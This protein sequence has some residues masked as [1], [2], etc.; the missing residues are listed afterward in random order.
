MHVATDAEVLKFLADHA[1][2][3]GIR[4]DG[5]TLYY[6][7]SGANC[8]EL[9][10]PKTPLKTTYFARVAAMMGISEEALFYGATLWIT[11]S[12]IGSPQLEKSGWKL[13][14]RMRQGFGENRS[15][16]TASGH[17]FRGDELVDLT[18]FLVPCFVYG[19]DAYV[20]FN[21]GNDFFVHISHDE[22]WGVVAR[23]REAYD[24]LFSELKDLNPKESPGMCRRFCRPT[25][26]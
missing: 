15:L 1:W 2:N 9:Q 11:L 16:Q 26:V 20:L 6:A 17:F 4:A 21:A 13:V 5:T 25:S 18:A 8:I 22:Y 10:F 3:H 14:E 12:T 24:R 19:W 7:D 23:T